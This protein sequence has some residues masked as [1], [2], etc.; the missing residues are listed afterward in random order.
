MVRDPN[1]NHVHGCQYSPYT[2]RTSFVCGTGNLYAG[3]RVHEVS[4]KMKVYW[5]LTYMGA[6]FNKESACIIV[7]WRELSN[8]FRFSCWTTN[9]VSKTPHKHS[10]PDSVD[11]KRTE[12]AICNSA[13]SRILT[14]GIYVI[15]TRTKYRCITDEANS[16]GGSQF[17]AVRAR[18][19]TS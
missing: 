6:P 1:L 12:W 19:T 7:F 8:K 5:A 10:Q 17:T 13:K 2:P 11:G 3:S 15:R 9:W 18:T 16:R 4:G 14:R